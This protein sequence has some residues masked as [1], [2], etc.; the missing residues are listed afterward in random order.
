MR[1]DADTTKPG[2]GKFICMT[3]DQCIFSA[4]QRTNGVSTAVSSPAYVE[5]S[6]RD[7]IEAGLFR[8]RRS[9]NGWVSR[10][11][12]EARSECACFLRGAAPSSDNYASRRTA[13]GCG[14]VGA[15]RDGR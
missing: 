8:V 13:E 11:A 14:A 1:W 9:G 5:K 4:L 12:A 10:R 6:R 3:D 7:V 15:N 2:K